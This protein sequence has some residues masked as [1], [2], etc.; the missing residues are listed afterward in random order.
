MAGFVQ[1]IEYRTSRFDEVKAMGEDYNRSGSGSLARN[2][3]MTEDRGRPG[4]YMT[5]VEFDSYE[6][7]MK[8][9]ERP[10]TS[11]F[12][13]KMQKLCDGPPKFYNLDIRNSIDVS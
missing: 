5:I 10:E 13:E 2:V 12:A 6:S 9:S 8:N 11:A 7:A 4:T 1:I 3:R